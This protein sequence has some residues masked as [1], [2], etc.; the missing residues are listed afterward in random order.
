MALVRMFF[1]CSVLLVGA[2]VAMFFV[3]GG[4]QAIAAGV[5]IFAGSG[6]LGALIAFGAARDHTA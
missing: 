4:W 3:T 5:M 6:L 2:V 1:V